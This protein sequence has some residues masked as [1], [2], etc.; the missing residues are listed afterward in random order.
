[1]KL[2]SVIR[3][4]IPYMLVVVFDEIIPVVSEEKV[5]QRNGISFGY[6]PFAPF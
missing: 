2:E 5:S 6:A 1:M 4:K 3:H